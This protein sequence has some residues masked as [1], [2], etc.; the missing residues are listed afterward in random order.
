[1]TDIHPHT[2]VIILNWNGKKYLDQFLP[3]LVKYTTRPG[4]ELV[5]ADNGSSDG[6]VQFLKKAFPGIR[7]INFPK[8]YGFAAGYNRAIEATEA[9]YVVLLNSD[10]EV[11]PGW[12]DPLIG[13]LENDPDVAACMPRIR[14]WH[15]RDY[16]EYAGAAGGF[17]DRWGYPFCRGR[18]LNHIEPDAGQYD[19]ERDIFWATGACMVIRR[20]IYLKAGGLDERFFAHMEEIDLCWRI[21][22]M[23]YRIVY[24]PG[25]IVYHVGGGTLPNEH[26]HKLYL[27]FRNNLLTLCKNLPRGKRG[28]TLIIRTGLDALA[29]LKYILTWQPANAWAVF[30]AY[31]GFMRHLKHCKRE[32]KRWLARYPL[33]DHAEIY[34][35][36]ILIQFFLRKRKTF[37]ELKF[38]GKTG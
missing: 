11:T 2:A 23:G 27:N 29:A 3:I 22:N 6:S 26:P 13:L 1:M 32:R 34:G 7:L 10:V 5:V 4:T 15:R 33:N 24:Y 20:S 37:R 21:K 35:G 28:I 18:I 12:L 25:S 17:I 14:S 19:K 31:G 16:F 30:R 8:N 9:E 38:P 36:S